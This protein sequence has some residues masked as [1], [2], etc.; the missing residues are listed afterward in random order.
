[1]LGSKKIYN[2]GHF[3]QIPENEKY[4]KV[5][6]LIFESINDVGTGNHKQVA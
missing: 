1:M 3:A 6:N 2:I 5:T 4:K